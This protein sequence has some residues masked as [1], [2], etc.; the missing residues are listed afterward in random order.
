MFR[1]ENTKFNLNHW[2][3]NISGSERAST[4]GGDFSSAGLNITESSVISRRYG[5]NMFS[6]KGYNLQQFSPNMKHSSQFD[7][8]NC[9]DP[10]LAANMA[11]LAFNLNPTKY[12][13]KK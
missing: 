9:C 11:S 10:V 2:S 1:F 12:K 13:S 6:Y 4:D 5:N 3:Y 7:G 8:E